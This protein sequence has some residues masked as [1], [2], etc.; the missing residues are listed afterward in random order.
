MLDFPSYSD[1][2][3]SIGRIREC[4]SYISVKARKIFVAI[5]RAEQNTRVK[6][7]IFTILAVEDGGSEG[8]KAANWAI[9]GLPG[10]ATPRRVSAAPHSDER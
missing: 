7:V 8:M 5:A 4:Q 6:K 2:H 10:M 9:G 3:P 1:C